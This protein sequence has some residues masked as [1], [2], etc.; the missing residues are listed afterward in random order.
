M[1]APIKQQA[2][3]LFAELQRVDWPNREKVISSTA[4]VIVISLFVGIF[5]WL[6]DLGLTWA[7]QYILPHH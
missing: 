3:D 6:A 1:I 4:T 5:L 7:M 2:K